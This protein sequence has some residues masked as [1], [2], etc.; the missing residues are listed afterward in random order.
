MRIVVGSALTAVAATIEAVLLIASLLTG[1][2]ATL[3][4]LTSS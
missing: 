4:R 3:A 1:L 2:V